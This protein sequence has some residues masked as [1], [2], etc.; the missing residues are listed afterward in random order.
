MT[1]QGQAPPPGWYPAQ[2]DPP[3]TQRYWDGHHW[4]T[5]PQLVGPGYGS[6]PYMP[7]PAYLPELGRS[8]AEPA[9]R[10]VARL[11]DAAFALVLALI[12]VAAFGLDTGYRS[13]GLLATSAVIGVL[14]EVGMVARFAGTAG[15][16]LVGIGVITVDGQIPPGL[17]PALLR[18]L[19]AAL[20]L[21]PLAGVFISAALGLV[22][23]IWL[24]TDVRRRTI[25]DK[26]AK[27]YVVKT[28]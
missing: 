2:G 22:S 21:I 13:P 26:L 4:T 20:G 24:F 7:D 28:R 12:V 15:K 9:M 5:G 19:P 27:T 8:L 6:G 25:N 10:I 16:L 1:D 17:Q 23:L 11:I 3:G 14:Y 18:W